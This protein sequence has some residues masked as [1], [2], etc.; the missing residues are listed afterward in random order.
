MK[1]KNVMRFI[2]AFIVVTGTLAYCACNMNSM[3]EIITKK[4]PFNGVVEIQ[5]LKDIRAVNLTWQED[6]GAN[7]YIVMRSIYDENGFVEFLPIFSG[8]ER[9][10]LD[11]D[12]AVAVT[13]AYRLDKIK[14]NK[15]FEGS[16]CVYYFRSEPS[17]GV[18]TAQS[19]NDGR[20]V[21]LSWEADENADK[22]IVM[23]TEAGGNGVDFNDEYATEKIEIINVC[24]YIDNTVAAERSYAYR[25]DKVC[26]NQVFQGKEVTFFG[27]TRPDPFPG[28]IVMQNLN[29]GKSA[30]LT[31]DFDIG[32]D[33]YRIMRADN[34]GISMFFVE[35]Q[36]GVDGFYL[37]GA[38]SALDSALEDGKGYF[39][40][41]D[42]KRDGVWIAGLEM[43]EFSRTRPD[44]FPGTIDILSLNNGKSAF[45]TWMA[46]PG[47]DEYRIMRAENDGG[48]VV[49][50]ER[51]N[52]ADGFLR[53][54]ATSALDSALDAGKG[55]FYRLDK[56]RNGGWIVGLEITELLRTRPNPFPGIIDVQ[57]LNNGKSAFLTWQA[58]PG[59]DEYRVMRSDSGGIAVNFIERESGIDGFLRQGVTSALDSALDDGKG[60]FYRLDKKRDGVWVTGL[61]VTE[62][63]RTRP[64]PF[65]GVIGVQ[66]WNN[67]KAAFLTWQADP[68]ADEYRIMRADSG[69]LTVNFAERKD[70]VDGFSLQGLTTALDGALDDGQGYFYRLDKKRDGVWIEGLTVTEFTKTRPDPFPGVITAQKWNNGKSAFL[71]W[72][73]DPGAD[74]YRVMRAER[75]GIAL[76]FAEREDGEDGF[77]IQGA[78]S[79]LD[80][81]LDDGKGYFYR[82]DKKRDGVWVEGL[83]VTELTKT[84]P[85]PF[86]GV[87]TAQKR[88]NGKAAF[89]TW[90]EDPGADE[91]RVMRADKD[92]SELRFD[93]R[94]GMSGF[95][96]E[97][98]TSALDSVDDDK[99]YFYRL[100][101]KRD[102]VWIDGLTVTELTKTRPDPFPG[103]IA[104]Q[105]LN[106]GKTAYLTWQADPGAD[107]YRVM[108]A[109]NDG[110]TMVFRERLDT[111][112]GFY[113]QGTTSAMDTALADDVGYFY[114]L[115]KKRGGEWT[116][117]LAI[118][119]FSRTRPMPAAATP[120]VKSFRAD[121]YIQI[122]WQNDEGADAYRLMRSND[123]PLL[124]YRQVY[125]GSA[126]Q[127]LDNE[128][129]SQTQVR[130][131]YKLNKIRNGTEYEGDRIALGVSVL[132]QEDNHEPNNT[133]AEATILE[134]AL[135][136][137]LY[138][139]GFSQNM[140]LEDI[141]WYKV[142]IPPGKKANIA[143][144]YANEANTGFFWLY[145]PYFPETTIEHNQAFQVT[146][147]GSVQK[148]V[149][150]AIRPNRT[151]FLYNGAGGSIQGYTITWQSVE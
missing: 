51:Q 139:Y 101:K 124:S 27:K 73:E 69:G 84:R 122:S 127:Y 14:G 135:E 48:V 64:D 4:D 109:I 58:D 114:R 108:R 61:D 31:W 53:Q 94:N 116:A 40:R 145:I 70:G 111:V 86:P 132:T 129:D 16:G 65:P 42:K 54:G 12:I 96:I 6:A 85:D 99:G 20:S 15:I 95:Y 107:E 1:N 50:L 11:R 55:Y 78:N 142:N 149:A 63:I 7:K 26:G 52:G 93:L 5:E 128:V 45:L 41:L 19:I 37:Q 131:I 148:Y 126:L 79:A 74:E 125:L 123:G 110:S 35:R 72:Q 67:G 103:V 104:A 87:I 150:F 100:D 28:I 80:S 146:N 71:T 30:F 138:C 18:I 102:N 119:E 22:Y 10:Y 120:V 24:S 136:A 75:D 77:Y 44:P 76:R 29:N 90:Q 133:E 113:T 21:Y 49:F 25:L 112:D 137:N 105:N 3:N 62:F 121:G 60:Y 2:K 140:I 151:E 97:G 56:K 17:G 117:G 46:D 32:A 36:N 134:S 147:D 115:D 106:N 68:G 91:Y 143:V 13:Y 59:A 89:L 34:D 141:D 83:T 66:K 118:T 130:Y 92:G 81:V 23:K 43:S 8:I 9:E 98:A 82:L 33:G 144:S 57:N 88:D 47:A 39:Y 38:T